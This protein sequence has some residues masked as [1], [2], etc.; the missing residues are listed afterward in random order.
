MLTQTYLRR[1]FPYAILAVIS[2]IMLP[3]LFGR[4][5]GLQLNWS[6]SENNPLGLYGNFVGIACGLL[7]VAAWIPLLELLKGTGFRTL[8]LSTRSLATFLWLAPSYLILVS[9]LILQYGYQVVFETDWPI[10]TT[11]VCL[12]AFCM[13]CLSL[14][15]WVKFRLPRILLAAGLIVGWGVWF[16]SRFY[17]NGF[18]QAIVVWTAL[19]PLDAIILLATVAGSW[20]LQVV[21]FASSRCNE[22]RSTWLEKLTEQQVYAA[23]SDEVEMEFPNYHSPCAGLLAMEWTKGRVISKW[24][25]IILSAFFLMTICGVLLQERTNIRSVASSIPIFAG[26]GGLLVGVWMAA[27]WSGSQKQP[28]MKPFVASLPFSDAA[29][30]QALHWSILKS[31]TVAGVMSLISLLIPVL[32]FIEPSNLSAVFSQIFGLPDFGLIGGLLLIPLSL[33]AGWAVSGLAASVVATGRVWLGIAAYVLIAGVPVTATFLSEFGGPTGESIV[34]VL[35]VATAALIALTSGTC[36]VVAKRR[37]FIENRTLAI[38]SMVTL[39]LVLAMIS[40]AA[41]DPYHQFLGSCLAPLAVLPFAS[42][43]LAVS[44]NRHR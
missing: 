10:F 34:E 16:A 5:V 36:F 9:G 8:P 41:G 21:A 35:Q 23:S 18:R 7:G 40:V 11:T 17:P 19:S 28:T 20:R 14:G 4:M 13:M 22:F 1:A 6:V 15:N 33:V 32:I 12:V 3:W 44:W 39:A 26:L 30:S 38:C 2:A 37:D 43:P 29:L 25:G 27:E 24:S 31:V 42:L